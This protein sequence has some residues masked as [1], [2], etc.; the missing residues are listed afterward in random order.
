VADVG[1]TEGAHLP[2]VGTSLTRGTVARFGAEVL[3]VGLGFLTGL[4]TARSL[5][6]DGKGVLSTLGYLSVLAAAAAA[7]GLGEAGVTAVAQG[8]RTL[9]EV[10]SATIGALLASSGIA[11]VAFVVVAVLQFVDLY[12][13]L[14]LVLLLTALAVPM[15]AVA[16]VLSVFIDAKRQFVVS[17][18]IRVVMATVTAVGTVAL[19]LGGRWDL[20]GAVIAAVAGWGSGALLAALALRRFG[21]P[22]RPRWDP[23]YL[24]W[25]VR[26][27]V[28][29]QVSYLLMTLGA[30]VDLL[31]VN[32]IA[33]TIPAGRYSV[34]LTIG[35]LVTY[36]PFVLALVAYPHL[37]DLPED[38]LGPFV[39]RLSRLA[40]LS[41]FVAAIGMA[42]GL[43]VLL[44][45]V[46]GKAYG[47]STAPA[48]LL[49][50]A[51][52]LWS[53]QWVLCRARAA[54]GDGRLLLRSYLLSLVVM[55]AFDV[56]LIPW[57]DLVGAGLASVFGGAAGAGMSLVSYRRVEDVAWRTLVVPHR[58]DAAAL[59][60][61]AGR[62]VRPIIGALGGRGE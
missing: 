17:A 53:V 51:G 50:A 18:V 10:V 30:R 29:V 14:T 34:S 45:L 52:V 48:I 59:H 47:G 19:V 46:F 25:A 62:L 36:G 23:R 13:D 24:R 61:L 20:D 35:A 38:E 42:L 60:Q 33:G 8:R 2:P 55:V 1:S 58:A 39:A 26:L 5:G 32:G 57:L 40:V 21:L 43:P 4:V 6:P 49:A 56:V 3:G 12:H 11:A 54:R 28:P 22:L 31:L 15:I 9:E 41:S 44:P 7:L 37:A 16:G 27:G